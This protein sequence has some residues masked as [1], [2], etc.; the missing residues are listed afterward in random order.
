LQVITAAE[1]RFFTQKIRVLPADTAARYELAVRLYRSGK[2]QE[3]VQELQATRESPRH[4]WQ[5]L[6]YLG[7]SFEKLGVWRLAQ[8]NLK[9]ALS[10]TPASELDWRKRMLYHLA[11]GAAAAGELDE[12][13]E[14]GFELANLDFTHRHIDQLL[15]DWQKRRDAGVSEE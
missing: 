2:Y 10:K 13:I 4:Q 15:A 8:R 7:L 9:D 3:A 5:S 12:A 1:L 6:A 11:K 14:M